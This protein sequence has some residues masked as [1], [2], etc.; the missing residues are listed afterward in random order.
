M[1]FAFAALAPPLR[2]CGCLFARVALLVSPGDHSHDFVETAARNAYL[3]VTL[4][5]D[6]DAAVRHLLQGLD[7]S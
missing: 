5:R 7:E 2:H 1:V 3:D 6:K 4:F